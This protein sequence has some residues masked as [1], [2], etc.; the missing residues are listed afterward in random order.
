[1]VILLFRVRRHFALISCLRPRARKLGHRGGAPDHLALQFLDNLVLLADQINQA[2]SLVVEHLDA[3]AVEHELVRL[4]VV[5]PQHR[6][7]VHQ[8]QLHLVEQL[9]E[10]QALRRV[11]PIFG[12]QLLDF[13]VLHVSLDILDLSLSVSDHILL[14]SKL[15]LQPDQEYALQKEKLAQKAKILVP[16]HFD[17]SEGPFPG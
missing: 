9:S 15:S 10:A 16:L 11:L 5:G 8:L 3:L 1:M 7:V 14:L 12:D 2:M 4:V 6:L 13:R 17:G